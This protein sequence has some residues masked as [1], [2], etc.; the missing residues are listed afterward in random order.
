MS[1]AAS[2]KPYEPVSK[3]TTQTMLFHRRGAKDR[4]IRLRPPNR[5]HTEWVRR[6]P[7][8]PEADKQ[9]LDG[10]TGFVAGKHHEEDK[11]Q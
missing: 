5:L 7:H 4:S 3:V 6:T 9:E 8:V 1:W 10:S 11:A 2:G